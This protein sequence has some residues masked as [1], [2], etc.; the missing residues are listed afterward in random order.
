[1]NIFLIKLFGYSLNISQRLEKM[2]TLRMLLKMWTTIF[3]LCSMRKIIFLNQHNASVWRTATE[4]C[5]SL[6]WL[7]AKL[8]PIPRLPFSNTKLPKCTWICVEPIWLVLGNL[9]THVHMDS[10]WLIATEVCPSLINS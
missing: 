4:V 6:S 1:M 10:V 7:S 3:N 9:D 5:P 8:L 2:M